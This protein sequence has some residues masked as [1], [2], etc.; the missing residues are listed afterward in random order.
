MARLIVRIEWAYAAN[1]PAGDRPPVRQVSHDH[2]FRN[3]DVSHVR[4][5]LDDV[6]Y[7]LGPV[8][9]R[10]EVKTW[11]MVAIVEVRKDSKT[12]E[13]GAYV[14]QWPC[15]MAFPDDD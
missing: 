11:P 5:L 15:R 9:E 1:L 3:P 7:E 14:H 12:R 6:G 8:D 4:G 2:P 10:V 13:H